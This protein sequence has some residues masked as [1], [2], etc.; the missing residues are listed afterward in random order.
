M[1]LAFVV[2]GGQG[3]VSG[4]GQHG[5]ADVRPEAAER[6]MAQAHVKNPK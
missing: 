1:H 6:D 3:A 2:S 4:P 5:L